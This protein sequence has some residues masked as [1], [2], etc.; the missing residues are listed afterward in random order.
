MW[1]QNIRITK[2]LYYKAHT[3]FLFYYY[4]YLQCLQTFFI[5]SDFWFWCCDLD[6][7][8]FQVRACKRNGSVVIS[9]TS[10][11]H[12]QALQK[13]V[14]L[15]LATDLSNHVVTLEYNS[16]Y[17]MIYVVWFLKVISISC[18]TPLLWNIT[19]LPLTCMVQ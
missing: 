5:N 15:L 6:I 9:C 13:P 2:V 1:I 12:I 16:K 19:Y 17:A 14:I 8:R 7:F 4:E 11:T 3:V 18:I 10:Q